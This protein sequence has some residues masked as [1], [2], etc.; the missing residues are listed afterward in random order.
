MLRES[1]SEK[2][3]FNNNLRN[4]TQLN[5]SCFSLKMLVLFFLDQTTITYSAPKQ[6]LFLSSS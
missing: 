1:D 6:K 5:K 2:K 3:S 4:Q